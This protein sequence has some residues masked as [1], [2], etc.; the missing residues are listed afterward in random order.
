MQNIKWTVK[1]PLTQGRFW[2]TSQEGQAPT[3]V[4]IE[5]QSLGFYVLGMGWLPYQPGHWA[6]P[7][8][9]HDPANN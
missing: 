5:K 2:W 6:G 1:K 4:Y 3:L 9:E 8:S 7:V